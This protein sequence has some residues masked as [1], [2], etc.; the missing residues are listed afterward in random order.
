[1]HSVTWEILL[2]MQLFVVRLKRLKFCSVAEIRRKPLIIVNVHD[3]RAIS[4]TYENH[5]AAIVAI[6]VMSVKITL[7][8]PSEQAD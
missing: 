4:L 2:V 7:A 1:M 3:W 8:L 5:C 6:V